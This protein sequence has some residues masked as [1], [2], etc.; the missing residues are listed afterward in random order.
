MDKK[1][2]NS[3]AY[4]K[5]VFNKKTGFST[6][7]N[8]FEEVDNSFTTFLSE[9]KLPKNTAFKAPNN[10]FE[11]LEEAI[12]LKVTSTEKEVKV[13]SLKD[14]LLKIIP[15]AAAASVVLFLSLNSFLFQKTEE[16]SF[17]SI[18]INDVEYWFNDAATTINT[19]DITT[20]LTD[21]DLVDDNFSLAVINDD[22]LEDYFNSIDNS[23]LLEDLN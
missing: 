11:G 4:L 8:Y 6:P 1:K 5:S 20:I 13:I 21:E 18:A 9:E 15:I 23:S 12:L 19:E 10:Y 16:I 7:N 17:D 14:R 2:Q 22:S 3:E